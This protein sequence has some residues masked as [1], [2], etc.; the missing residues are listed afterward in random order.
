MS[1]YL[2][3]N[4]LYVLSA[5]GEKVGNFAW[6]YLG[7]ELRGGS[8]DSLLFESPTG[9]RMEIPAN[10]EYVIVQAEYAEIVQAT[11]AFI[12]SRRD[13]DNASIRMWQD[14]SRGKAAN[15]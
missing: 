4:K 13:I 12:E 11:Q 6:T 5:K 9:T 10:N 8:G 15:G 3:E 7:A 1:T 14:K 2:V